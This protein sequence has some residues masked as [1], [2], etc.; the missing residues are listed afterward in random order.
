[1]IDA[2]RLQPEIYPLTGIRAVA[3][4]GVVLCH[5]QPRIAAAYPHLNFLIAPIIAHGY[6]GVDLFFILSGFILQYNY[7]DRLAA[8]RVSAAVEFLWMR[9]ARIWPVHAVMLLLFA[10]LLWMQRR[11]G[12]HPV[13]PD[14]YGTADFFWNLLLVHGW[15]IPLKMSWNVPAWSVSCEWLAY[16]AFPFLVATRLCT[17]S[18]RLSALVAALALGGTVSVCWLLHAVDNPDYGVVRIT[19][20]FIAGC[21]LCH[22]FRTGVVRC[23]PWHY[24]VPS[25]IVAL[26]AGAYCFFSAFGL[27]DYWGVPFLG[28]IVLVLAHQRCWVARVCSS[29]PL[30][31]GGYISY[32]IYMVHELILIVMKK[33]DEHSSAVFGPIIDL[34]AVVAAAAG[35]YYLVERPC[36][37]ALRNVFPRDQA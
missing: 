23:F 22:V 27:V 30:L 17:A 1:M 29:K 13:R 12:S 21:A 37:N 5:L 11:L 2:K 31:F 25:A 15:A 35:L 18:A 34:F 26:V 3:A 7:A 33:T 32:S 10:L 14:L 9:L 36:R 20:E 19:G 8:F 16:L 6:L 28:V 24:I 4:I